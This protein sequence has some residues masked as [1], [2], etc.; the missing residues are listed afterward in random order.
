MAVSQSPKM[1][2]YPDPRGKGSGGSRPARWRSG[3]SLWISAR[4][5]TA[6][7]STGAGVPV[8]NARTWSSTCAAAAQS[9]RSSGSGS[10][11]GASRFMSAVYRQA[12]FSSLRR[13][14]PPRASASAASAV[15]RRPDPTPGASSEMVS[16][17]SGRRT[18]WRTTSARAETPRTARSRSA[19]LEGEDRCSSLTLPGVVRR[20]AALLEGSFVQRGPPSAQTCAARS[21]KAPLAGVGSRDAAFFR[22]TFEMSHPYR[23]HQPMASP[24]SRA[25]GSGKAAVSRSRPSGSISTDG[26]CSSQPG[27]PKA[28]HWRH[29]I[30][31]S[32]SSRARRRSV[33]SNAMSAV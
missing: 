29:A 19:S 7:T 32:R 26:S 18:S 3:S 11:I 28:A 1:A 4:A 30:S 13:S 10:T 31:V 27:T 14:R 16:Q 15:F 25:A 22:R 23:T 20:N 6:R 2:Q 17:A 5:S 9:R 8:S 12:F 33:S 24:R 21:R